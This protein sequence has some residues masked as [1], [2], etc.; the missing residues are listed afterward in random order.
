VAVKVEPTEPKA[1]A[2]ANR[3][4][5]RAALCD[6]GIRLNQRL[7]TNAYRCYSSITFRVMVSGLPLRPPAL[8]IE[9]GVALRVCEPTL[10]VQEE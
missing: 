9:K 3:W 4:N 7:N 1:G 2:G 8:D 10:G 6:E 5:P